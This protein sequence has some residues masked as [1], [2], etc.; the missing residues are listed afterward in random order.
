V[1]TAMSVLCGHSPLP[2]VPVPTPTLLQPST[3][4]TANFPPSRTETKNQP[5]LLNAWRTRTH[6]VHHLPLIQGNDQILQEI[7][8]SDEA[9][10]Q[11]RFLPNFL[12]LGHSQVLYNREKTLLC[13]GQPSST[14]KPQRKSAASIALVA[15]NFI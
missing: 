5:T 4:T 6:A 9:G 3:A 11:R 15:D 1:P 2:T 7:F 10:R 12:R 8:R 13:I 14:R